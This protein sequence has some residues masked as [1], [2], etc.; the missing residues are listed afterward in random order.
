[1][2]LVREIEVVEGDLTGGATVSRM[3][4]PPWGLFGGR[5]GARLTVEVVRADGSVEPLPPG[6]AGQREIRLQPGDGLT[7]TTPGGGGYGDPRQRERSLVTRDLQEERISRRAA[8]D[9]YG[10]ALEEA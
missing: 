7:V 1:M 10:L 8:V 9:H 4:V 2:G 6:P 3:T 5:P